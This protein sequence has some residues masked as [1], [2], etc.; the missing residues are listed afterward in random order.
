MAA[1]WVLSMALPTQGGRSL[2]ERRIGVLGVWKVF[3]YSLVSSETNDV[4][5]CGCS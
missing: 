1:H 4:S 3:C 2:F 5:L